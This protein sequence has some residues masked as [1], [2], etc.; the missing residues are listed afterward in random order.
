ML[1]KNILISF[2]ED[3]Y[4]LLNVIQLMKDGWYYIRSPRDYKA[5]WFKPYEIW[6]NLGTL[7]SEETHEVVRVFY[8]FV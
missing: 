1:A 2:N 3:D 6:D 4:L 7:E 8:K 5:Y